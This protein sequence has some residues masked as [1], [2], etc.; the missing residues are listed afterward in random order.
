[1][2]EPKVTDA[3]GFIGLGSQGAPIARR[4]IDAGLNVT[5]WARRPQSLD[6]YRQT[7]ARFAE[8]P[9]ALAA[10]TQHI[11]V[12]VLN[13]DD[14]KQVCAELIPAMRP[15]GRIAIHSTVHPNTCQQLAAQAGERG[16]ALIDAPVSGGAPAAEAG[17]LTVMVGGEM[18]DFEAARPI[19]NTFGR[20]IVHLGPVGAGQ[21]A[22]LINNTLMAA[23]LAMAYNALQA[24]GK[25]GLARAA[26][27]Q[28]LGAS[29]A[30]SFA[31]DV[32]AR[33]SSPTGFA[34]GAS[35]LAKDVRLLGEVMHA[36]S[37]DFEGLR[38]AATPF[39][40]LALGEPEPGDLA[41]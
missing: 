15:G 38:A 41:D 29:S 25:L 32:C 12:C 35:L 22:K 23:N 37:R 3:C 27:V 33:M 28:L 4:M 30:R 19:F 31:L 2:T 24:G 40:G 9:A 5:L 10:A 1:M 36:G 13:D 6:A 34:H 8:S 18:G 20:L 21:I 26:L 14:V 7:A 39:L 16:I 11:G 17:A